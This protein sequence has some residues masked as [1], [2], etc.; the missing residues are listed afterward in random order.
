MG[1]PVKTATEIAARN[2][3][4]IRKYERGWSMR[5]LAMAYDL[6]ISRVHEI[7][8]KSGVPRRPRGAKRGTPSMPRSWATPPR[9]RLPWREEIAE[10]LRELQQRSD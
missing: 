9:P 4:L 1:H 7:V 5:M 2:T 3:E 10:R 8:V 6:D